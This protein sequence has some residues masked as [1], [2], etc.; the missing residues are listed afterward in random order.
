MNYYIAVPAAL[1]IAL[2][3]WLAIPALATVER[4]NQA[5]V[6]EHKD[7]YQINDDYEQSEQAKTVKAANESLRRIRGGL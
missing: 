2:N 7:F 1:I 4:N 6:E 3:V 5:V